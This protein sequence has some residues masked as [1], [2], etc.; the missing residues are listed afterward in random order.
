V[1]ISYTLKRCLPIPSGEI[2][3]QG[4]FMYATHFGALE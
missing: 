3:I 1:V 2:T 4:Q